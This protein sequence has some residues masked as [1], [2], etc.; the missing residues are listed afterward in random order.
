MLAG[1]KRVIFKYNLIAALGKR[2]KPR[3]QQK[4]GNNKD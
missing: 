2:T 3:S 4:E 1:F